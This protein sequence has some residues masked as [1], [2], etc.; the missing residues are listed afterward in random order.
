MITLILLTFSG[1]CQLPDV[2]EDTILHCSPDL[3]RETEEKDNFCPGIYLH[4]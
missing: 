2:M 1:V 4:Q 3:T